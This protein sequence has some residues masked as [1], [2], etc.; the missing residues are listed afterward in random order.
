MDNTARTWAEIDL[1][2]IKHNLASIKKLIGPDTTLMAVVKA[3]A[4][5]HGMVEVV[6]TALAAG[7]GFFGVAS[8]EEAMELRRSGINA[9][10]LVL[11]YIPIQYAPIVIENNISATVFDLE[12][13]QAYSR[14]SGRSKAKVHIK[15]DTGMGRIGFIP[16][17]QS[18]R[19]IKTISRLPG[20]EIEGIYTHFAAADQKDKSYTNR[21]LNLFRQITGELEAAGIRPR[22]RH[23]ANSAAIMDMSE[24]RFDMV[25]SG[26]ITYGLY[27]SN[28]VQ[29]N[30]LDLIPA[31]RLKSRVTMVKTLKKGEAVSYGCTFVSPADMKV[32]TVA[33]GYADGYT[34]SLSNRAWATLKGH[35]VPLIGTV[36]MDQC[37]FDVSEIPQVKTGDE[38]ILFGRPEDGITVDDLAGIAKT[39][40]YEMVC[41]ITPRVPRVY[42]S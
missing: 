20:I 16:E 42:I 27:P 29:R 18:V 10:I 40:N 13:A 38:I 37:M 24:T 12:T 4:Y 28:E 33:A 30:N 32:A 26:I 35:R 19:D 2:A 21:Q 9:P 6:R 3:N 34:R 14:A 11:G 7:A 5:G 31:M 25:R 22:F 1:T 15:L 23:A 17:E 36:C 39:I 41:L 8:L